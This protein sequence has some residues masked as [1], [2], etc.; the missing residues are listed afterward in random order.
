MKQPLDL[1]KLTA[2]IPG[3]NPAGEDLRYTP[4]YEEMKEARRADDPFDRGDWQ[5]E[6]KRADWPKVIALTTEA[7]AG[8]SKDLQ[9]VAWL[10]E[11]LVTTDGWEGAAFGLRL[12]TALLTDYWDQ[13]YPEIEDGDLEFRAGP[14]EFLNERLGVS[15]KEIPLTDPKTTPGYPWLKWQESRTVGYEAD[16]RNRYGDTDEE[17]RRTREERIGEGKLSAEEFDGAVTG[18]PGSFYV[19]LTKDV[20]ATR[21]AFDKLDSVLDE[22][23]GKDAPRLAEMKESIEECQRLVTKL[24]KEKKAADPTIETDEMP[25]NPGPSGT[26]EDVAP[27]LP[28]ATVQSTPPASSTVYTAFPV[29]TLASTDGSEDRLWTEALQTMQSAGMRTALGQILSAACSAPSVREK[30]RLRLLMAKLCLKADRPDL[31]RPIAEELHGIIEE[32]HLDRWESAVWIADVLDVLYQC[33]TRGEPSDDDLNRARTLFQRL[34]TTDVTKAA[35]Y[36]LP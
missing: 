17:K 29:S 7:I 27:V 30:N 31:A 12:M 28:G 13:L 14:I 6:L 33:L 9:I 26:V 22:R 8:K 19:A 23:F 4:I 10:T 32:L 20:A 16:T 24:L 2:P 18:S 3:D 15:L 21:E 5:R 35:S 34:C 11:A 36:K 25:T 1:D